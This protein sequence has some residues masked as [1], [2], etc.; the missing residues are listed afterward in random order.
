MVITSSLEQRYPRQDVG[1]GQRDRP[2]D[3]WKQRYW[4][5]HRPEAC[6]TKGQGD[7]CRRAPSCRKIAYA[8]LRPR[9]WWDILGLTSAPAT[10]QFY[11]TLDIS[12][13]RDI[14]AVGERIRAEHGDPTVIINNA[15]IGNG[16]SILDLPEERLRRIFDVNI[17]AHFLLLREFLPAMVRADHGHIVTIASMA[18]FSTQATNVDYACT[19]AGALVLH[20]GIGQELKHIYKA[21]RIRTS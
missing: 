21:P 11:Y 1:L 12:S 13:S 19:K 15:G 17:I 7:H 3:R 6:P 9:F 14:K 2:A 5:C 20:E 8:L 16:K 18:S 4:I 10:N